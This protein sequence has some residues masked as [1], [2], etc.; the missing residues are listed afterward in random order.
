MH[1]LGTGVPRNRDLA[2]GWLSRSATQ[3]DARAVELKKEP[4]RV[5]FLPVAMAVTR[6]LHHMS[7]IFEHNCKQDQVF[8]R[9][10]IDRKRWRELRIALGHMPDNYENVGIC[11]Q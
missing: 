9:L 10:Q 2:L 7:G 4:D 5:P 1:L 3:G 6:M 8:Q 11:I